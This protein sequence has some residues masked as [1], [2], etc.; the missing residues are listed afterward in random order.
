MKKI[1]VGGNLIEV[2]N[3]TDELSFLKG[4]RKGIDWAREHWK[5]KSK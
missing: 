3:D 4:Y 5:R 1:D 2:D